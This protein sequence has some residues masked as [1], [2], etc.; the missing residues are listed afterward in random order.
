MDLDG[1]HAFIYTPGSGFVEI[2]AGVGDF[3]PNGINNLGQVVGGRYSD[4]FDDA[5]DGF[6]YDGVRT[7]ILDKLVLNLAPDAH[8]YEA[9]AINDLGQITGDA[10]FGDGTIHAFRLDPVDVPNVPEPATWATMLGGFGMIGAMIRRRRAR[11]LRS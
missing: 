3:T 8:I 6:I 4:H 10:T 2:N 5:F 9:Y 11:A 1:R 7:R